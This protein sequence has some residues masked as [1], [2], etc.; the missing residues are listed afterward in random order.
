MKRNVGR[1]GESELKRWCEQVGITCNPSLVDEKAWDFL[2][3]FTL[4]IED[5]A[6]H[7]ENQLNIECKIQVK[8]TDGT[9]TYDDVKLSNWK[10]L[11]ESTLP[12]F[13]LALMFDGENDAQKA[14]LVHV[15]QDY[16]EMYLKRR[17]ELEQK[18]ELDKLHKKTMRFHWNASDQLTELTG[19]GLL[20]AILD[21][22][23]SSM[24]S[25]AKSKISNFE[26]AGI[27]ESSRQLKMEII[28]PEGYSANEYIADLELGLI[29]NAELNSFREIGSRFGIPIP[30]F[31][32]DSNEDNQASIAI[33]P[34]LDAPILKV[35][36]SSDQT[37]R[38]AVF[39][40]HLIKP[41]IALEVRKLRVVSRFL[42]IVISASLES[43][44]RLSKLDENGI[45]SIEDLE[46]YAN[47]V[48]IFSQPKED[49]INYLLE[50]E[51]EDDKIFKSD[52]LT[53]NFR[54]LK[55]YEEIAGTI[56][57]FAM[58]AR[59]FEIEM[60]K[61]VRLSHLTSSAQVINQ[62]K[63]IISPVNM[64]SRLEF[65]LIEGDTRVFVP[66]FR[67]FQI[68]NYQVFLVRMFTGLV[69]DAIE[70]DTQGKLWIENAYLEQEL[71]INHKINLD[72]F[73]GDTDELIK[74]LLFDM[75][76]V[77][78]KSGRVAMD[79]EMMENLYGNPK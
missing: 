16:Q 47:L 55:T 19:Q 39:K 33:R 72:T 14:F 26:T 8:S 51:I 30:E 43:R 79:S 4:P 48:K 7:D 52:T 57:N 56:L 32:F 49:A 46:A 31:E 12:C 58:I 45:Y 29:S 34:Q 9:A 37:V 63:I 23:G 22:I 44:L 69:A 50:M 11:A 35:I 10:D 5:E 78:S 65:E 27:T 71:Q 40:A 15:D 13:F 73:S 2:L 74:E 70:S 67:S 62:S 6:I 59:H 41:S 21:G 36:F 28:I 76:E 25:Y 38:K 66:F 24:H 53:G 18:G 77:A 75:F 54:F 60:S 17:R 3:E 68:S 42:D 61:I 1:L 20:N 64:K